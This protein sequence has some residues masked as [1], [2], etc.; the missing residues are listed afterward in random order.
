MFDK[1]KFA[2]FAI[3]AAF[4]SA[5]A[6]AQMVIDVGKINCEQYVHQKVSTPTLMAAWLSG[7]YHGQRGSL[8]VDLETL[9]SNANKLQNY[10]YVQ[11]NWKEPVV[12]AVE[13]L[14]GTA[15]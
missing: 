9:E 13:K 8:T 1:T 4:N 3:A 15:K 5:P 6:Q 2:L 11:D 12:K 7:Y 10:C 14:F